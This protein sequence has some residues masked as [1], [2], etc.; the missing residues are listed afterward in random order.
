MMPSVLRGFAL[1]SGC[2][3]RHEPSGFI[4]ADVTATTAVAICAVALVAGTARGFSG[5]GAALIFMPL[6]K[7]PR[8]TAARGRSAARHRFRRRGAAD[9][10]RVAAGR[11]QGHRGHGRRCV[12][13]RP[14]RHLFPH[15]AR[16]RD[17]ALDHF[18]IRWRA[19]AAA[20]VG[21]ALSRQR[22]MRRSRS[23]SAA[24]PAF[25]AG[26]RRPAVRRSS[27]TG[28]AGRSLRMSRAPTS[29]CSSVPPISF[30]SSAM[31]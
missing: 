13:R 20:A 25:A 24:S 4:P 21:L 12:G 30:P 26:S 10:E 19:A 27:A 3:H 6:G 18:R 22:T 15:P 16:S 8:R 1:A 11:P 5:F 29:C 2:K 31:P 28:S 14:G 17:H 9:S 23:A 7:Q